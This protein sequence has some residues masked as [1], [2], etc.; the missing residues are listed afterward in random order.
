MTPKARMV[1]ALEH[2]E[3]DRVPVGEMAIDFELTERILGHPT[4]YRAKWAEQLAEWEGRRD[5]IVESHKRDIVGLTR[6]LEL[7]YLAVLPVPA[8]R[9]K[10]DK[11]EFLGEYKW[12]DKAGRVWQYTPDS[13]GHPRVIEPIDMTS[14]GIEMPPD[15]A[16]VDPSQLEVVEHVVE[17]LGGTHFIIGRCPDGSFPHRETVG[18]EEFLTRMITDPEFVEK[19]IE[20][21]TRRSVAYIKALC[22]AGCDAVSPP[23]DYCDNRGP[24]MGPKHFRRFI[25]PSLKQMVEAAHSK[26]KLLIK[27]CDGNLWPIL[28]DFVEIG[29][30]GWQAIQPAIG[31][32]MRLLKERYGD[33]LTLFGGVD[34]D[35]L[36]AGSAQDVVEQVRYAVKY[37]GPGGGLVLTS[38]CTLLPGV[39]YENYMAMLQACR[40][41][42]R[43]PIDL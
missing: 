27:H 26:G 8:R 21:G 28:D 34:I 19:A 41:L 38:G 5:E 42:G 15:P 33:K 7:D 39:R 20:A 1:A 6:K 36:V 12:R 23:A 18:M 29:V 16:P 43:Y 4:L 37:A 32:D 40:E 35:T 11:P 3:P 10:Y 17:E 13:G 14:E 30:D 24:M 2:R 31:M 9:P 25:K 22:D